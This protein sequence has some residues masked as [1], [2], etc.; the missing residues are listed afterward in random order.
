MSQ[1]TV[2]LYPCVKLGYIRRE[3][4]ISFL[5]R[6]V[7]DAIWLVSG[8]G[9]EWTN[10][11]ECDLILKNSWNVFPPDIA[12]EERG[13]PIANATMEPPAGAI[14]PL[15]DGVRARNQRQRTV[16]IKEEDIVDQMPRV[17][18]RSIYGTPTGFGRAH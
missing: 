17:R 12:P 7:L 13:L 4:I 14:N 1:A 18:T 3:E 11:A 15:P 5:R 8:K 9:K 10:A 2:V 16:S 6:L